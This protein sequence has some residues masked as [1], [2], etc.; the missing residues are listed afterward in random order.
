MKTCSILQVVPLGRLTKTLSPLAV[1]VIALLIVGAGGCARAQE[2]KPLSLPLLH[3]LFSENAV[4]QRDRPVP[5]WGWTAPRSQVVVQFDNTRQTA[6]SGDDGRWTVSLA[7]H[8][9]GGPHSLS[10]T[11][12]DGAALT[13][14]NLLFGDVWLCSGQSNMAYD[15]QGALNPQAEIAAA[16]YPS[17]RL[18]QVPGQIKA[19][20]AQS[21]DADWKVCS[22][23]TVAKFAGTGYF[24]GR[25]LHKA[26]KVPIGLI[27]SS[28]SGTPG[29]SWISGPAL[30]QMPAFKPAVDA[31]EQ[32]TA[33]GDGAME[34]WWQKND[35]GT[36]ARQEAPAFD[37]S[38]WKSI[39]V[40][41]AWE[42]KGYADFDGVMWFRRVIEVP[43]AWAGR[44]LTLDMGGVD[45]VD[46][47]FWNGAV[48]GTGNGWDKARLYTVPGAQVKAGRNVI[49]VR[50]LD[51][52]GGG[53]VG[54]A[55]SMKSGNSTV[56]LAGAWKVSQGPA[57]QV[58]AAMPRPLDNP[59]APVVLFNGKIAPLLPAAIKGIAW[60]QGESN[61][62]NHAEAQQYRAILPVLVK[63][64]K[65]HFGAQTPFYI[66]QLA[67]FKAPDDAPSD[68]PWPHAREAQL[69]TSQRL[70]NTPLIVT[71]DLGEEKDVHYKNKQ[72]V[73]ARL[74]LSAL[75]N[76]YGV[77]IEGSGPTFKSAKVIDGALQL[78]FDHAAGLNLKGDAKRVFAVAGADGEFAWATPQI[79]GDTVTL[80]S[81]KVP[82][83]LFARFGWSDNPRAAL[84]NAAG[85]AAS[86]FR[87][88]Q[89]SAAAVE[90]GAADMMFNAF[91]K[92]FLVDG[93]YYK[94]S[95]SDAKPINTWQSSLNILVA[96]DAYERTGREAHKA[97]VNE[98]CASWL[99]RTPPPWEWDGW[100][101]D[102]GWFAMA[103][104]RGYQ[105]TGN[106]EF[107]KQAR[108][109]FGMAWARGW[110]TKY[111]GGGIWEQQPEKTPQGEKVSKEAISNDTLGLVACLL[112][113]STHEK[114]YLDRAVQ[115][116][117]WVRQTLYD[118]QTGQVYT[119]IERD[120]KIDKDAAVYNQG[121]FVDYANTLYQITGDAKYLQD[122]KRTIDYVKN[123]M[124]VNGILHDTPEYRD[125]WADTLARGLG[126]FVRDNRQWDAYHPWMQQNANAILKSRRP[127][128]NITS[129]AWNGATPTD[130][131]LKS[132]QFASAVAWL[133]FTPPSKPGAIAGTHAIVSAQG[134]VV[135]SGAGFENGDAIVLSRP[136]GGQSQKWSF[137]P[138]EDRSWNIISQS[139]WKA[140][141]CPGGAPTNALQMVQWQPS[142]EGNQRWLIE[143]QPDGS[144]K[145]ANKDSGL[146]LES[147]P[148][149][150]KLIQ[151]P[152]NGNA[153]QR[154]N[155]K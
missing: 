155:L 23:Q 6:T 17:I 13:R 24:F 3:P 85:L 107:L 25:E 127:D 37:D 40:P 54:P 45:D 26:L 89:E 128:Y 5:I 121:L 62:D 90:R 19:A 148:D 131:T 105:M 109:G 84:Y 106:A 116:Y 93:S 117:N 44:P 147:S 86:P 143:A 15:L 141:D 70:P 100:N 67:N 2:A 11:G 49:A 133:Q 149:G 77:K 114:L 154:W 115:I 78:V 94:Q 138:N 60:Y 42:E 32:S 7:P 74:A 103:L 53:L 132:T 81:D 36:R 31:L 151:A 33:A 122:A 140:L 110:D 22:P 10:V 126:R 80:R 125:T 135:D 118:P 48:V 104:M 75:A 21:F 144:Y 28:W 87:T 76:T 47:T 46:T 129:N 95:L 113:Q 142:R 136:S 16:N 1:P 38:S 79:A 145:I 120:N 83:P 139:S 9:A 12:A 72:E 59:N 146:A 66:V 63:D 119:G 92:A 50:V 14:K 98:L 150:S 35:P 29:E 130:N 20:P 73:G 108:Y 102:I 30:A 61:A 56:S 152:W 41:G 71:I 96:Q 51:N 124:T 4:L 123:H 68:K 57:L 153:R 27:D 55:I 43:A 65:A 8:A 88:D 64:W 58:L 34:A 91:N 39:Q 52:G 69:Q 101:D 97:L 137:T 99:R 111:N 134:G 82:A 18:M 112:Y